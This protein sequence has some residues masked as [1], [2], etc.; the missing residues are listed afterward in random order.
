M[1]TV[2]GSRITAEVTIKGISPYSQSRH[3]EEK[4]FENEDKGDYDKRTFRSHLHVVDGLVVIP[5]R[6][7]HECLI[8]AARYSGKQIPG[9]G[10]KTW[11]A[12]FE[13]GIGI[14]ADPSLG[15]KPEDVSYIDVYAH[16]SGIRGSG[17]RVSR[18][19]PQI[20]TPWQAT[21]E[22]NILD[23]IITEDVFREMM[24]I[25]GTFKGIGRYRPANGGTNG[26][27]ELAKLVWN[28]NRQLAA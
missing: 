25:A 26:R 10:K 6:A 21:F 13:S 16:A 15:V 11:T 28:A 7:I 1:S 14:F 20:L 4:A 27:F 22:V 9:Q 12:K 23:P 3:H 24:A 8:D 17:K 5:A 19:F 18:R 2:Y